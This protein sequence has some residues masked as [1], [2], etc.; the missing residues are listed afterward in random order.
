MNE[1]FRNTSRLLFYKKFCM[2]TVWL[3]KA[4]CPCQ[5]HRKSHI[6]CEWQ[7]P[8]PSEHITTL[9]LSFINRQDLGST[10]VKELHKDP[11]IHLPPDHYLL[12]AMAFPYVKLS[13]PEDTQNLYIQIDVQ[14]FPKS[15]STSIDLKKRFILHQIQIQMDQRLQYET[16]NSKTARR[17]HSQYPPR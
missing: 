3:S 6:L 2:D 10:E 9:Y 15:M 4:V 12:W 8:I 5:V 17:K 14:F 11:Y 13:N 16:W 1:R 7:L